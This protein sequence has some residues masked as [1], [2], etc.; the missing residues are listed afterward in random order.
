MPLR[1]GLL[2]YPAIAFLAMRGKKS[3]PQMLWHAGAVSPETA[4]R[5]EGI[6]VSDWRLVND[7]VRDGVIVRVPGSEGLCY[8]DAGVYR[9]RRAW[10]WGVLAAIGVLL[11]AFAVFIWR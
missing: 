10:A 6:G 9:R 5:P 7:Y 8:V 1:I 3:P 4:V 2:L 11:G